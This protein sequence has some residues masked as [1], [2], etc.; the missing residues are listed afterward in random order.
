MMKL[1][2]L[3]LCVLGIVAIM[4]NEEFDKFRDKKMQD[5]YEHKE[6]RN[7]FTAF[8]IIHC[9]LIYIYAMDFAIIAT[10]YEALQSYM[11][12]GALTIANAMTALLCLPLLWFSLK[13]TKKFRQFHNGEMKYL[14]GS[15]GGASA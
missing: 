4:F 14:D 7:S 8:L 13:V 1:L 12:G 2:V 10:L 15:D 5:Y 9:Y 6:K 3:P 11:L